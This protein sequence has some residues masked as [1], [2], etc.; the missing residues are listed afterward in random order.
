[1]AVPGL[2]C[3]SGCFSVAVSRAT[4]LLW[5]AGFS[6]WWLPLLVAS[7]VASHGLKGAWA[8]VVVACG[9]RNCGSRAPGT[10]E[11]VLMHGLS[12]PVACGISLD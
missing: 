5:C 7:L 8:S 9:L 6:L 3:C 1:M 10:S 4:L 2:C 12:C 11:V